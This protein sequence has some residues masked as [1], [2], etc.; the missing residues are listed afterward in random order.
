MA[1]PATTKPN[2]VP[3]PASTENAQPVVPGKRKRDNGEEGDELDG[4]EDEKPAAT[5]GWPKGD[6]KELIKSYFEVLSRYVAFSDL[7][8]SRLC[9][10]E[11]HCHAC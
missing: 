11:S 9:H 5:N 2:G 10:R 1:Q 7:W 6:Q 3:E 4:F 8:M